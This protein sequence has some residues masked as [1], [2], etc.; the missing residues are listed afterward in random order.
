[1]TKN[2]IKINEELKKSSLIRQSKYNGGDSITGKGF[3]KTSLFI[4]PMLGINF[5]EKPIFN[6]FINAFVD[7][8]NLDHNIKES[9]FILFKVKDVADKQWVAINDMLI[10]HK[11]YIYNYYVGEEDGCQLLMYVLQIPSYHLDNFNLIKQGKYSQ[12]SALYKN[13][14]PQYILLD[15]FQKTES[16][17]WGI[18][19]KSATLKDKIVKEFINPNTSTPEEVIE[20]R[21]EINTWNEIWDAFHEHE[22]TFTN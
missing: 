21:R 4:L 18:L 8:K 15:K 17:I 1:M 16:Q 13:L 6:F 11:C 14:F 3:T 10:K 5:K 19:N 22:E 20:L 7:D 2:E 12:T 9:V